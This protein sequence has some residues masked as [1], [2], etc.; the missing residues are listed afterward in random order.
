[1]KIYD[2]LSQKLKDFDT[3]ESNKIKMYV[4]GP[5]VYD[6]PH[7]GHARCY[8][9]WDMVVRYFRFK[10]YDV[11]YVRN[12][13]DVDDK[14]INKAKANNLSIEQ[15]SQTYYDEFQDAMQKLNIAPADIE[16]KAT[17]AI[18]EMI[19]IS[20][21][22]IEKGFAYVSGGDV[23]FRVA[24]YEKYGRLGKQNLEDLRAGARVESSDIKEDS[25]DFVLWKAVKTPNEPGWESPWGK[26]RPGW[27]IECSAM[28]KKYL[29]ETIDIHAGGQDLIF[30][31]H[32]NEKAQS[33]CAFDKPFAKYWMHN[34]FV[35]IG[36]EKMSKSLN[37]FVTIGDVLEKYDANAI[38]FF[39]LT[40]NY[41]MPVEFNDESL[42]AAKAGVKR[43]VNACSD[44]SD[45]LSADEILET[46]NVIKKIIND[47][48]IEKKDLIKIL[49]EIVEN[50]LSIEVSKE[51]IFT[52][53][54][55]LLNLFIKAMDEDFNTSKALAV[56]FEI[57]SLAQKAKDVSEKT[58]S[59]LYL[60]LLVRLSSVL[61]FELK[62]SVSAESD[63][64]EKLMEFIIS[65]RKEV[66]AEKNWALSDRIRDG[67]KEMGITLKDM[68]DGA[69][70]W[71]LDE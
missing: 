60:A 37:N 39:I 1:M 40:N 23:Y 15:I 5:T 47:V 29:G 41:R 25:M 24:K 66:R 31:H 17:E 28:I 18:D 43:L 6:Y 55:N 53:I 52:E 48:L 54:F 27:H 63:L 68:K 8:I 14:I 69:A 62:K 58:D 46:D 13:T 59:A 20:K 21:I 30:P 2:T 36:N 32:E 34:G 49:E 51:I 61:G 67:L 56:L 33:E 26:G 16:P 9:T 44:V 4:C 3:L 38:R 19:N 22:L 10:G 64:T 71:N 65:L 45:I 12:V 42:K 11:T 7:L 50:P 70:S 57:A 35:I